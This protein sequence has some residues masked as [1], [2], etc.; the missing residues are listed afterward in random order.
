M[1]IRGELFLLPALLASSLA[2]SQIPTGTIAGSVVDSSAASLAGASVQI[3][4]S[5]T[6][7]PRE[8]ITE[9]SGTFRVAN[10]PPG[11]YE[12]TVTKDGFHPLRQTGIQVEL[13]R[14]TELKLVLEV[15]HVTENLD[16]AAGGKG[17]DDAFSLVSDLLKFDEI[18]NLVQDSRTVTDLAYLVSGVGRNA[19][20]GLGSGFV[21]GGARADNTNFILD[22]F[23]DY[24]PR[25]G[26]A[27]AMP[28]Y[29]AVQEFRVQTTGSVAEFGHMAGG[30]MNIVLR[31]GTNRLHGSAFEF[32]RNSGLTARNFFDEQKSYLL[33][34]QFGATLSGPVTAPHL[35]NGHDRTFF[36]VSWE[37]LHQSSGQNQLSEVPTMLERAGDFSQSLGATGKP[38]V[39][40]DPLTRSPFPLDRIPQSR[41]DP[42]AARL[43]GFYP[44]P[45]NVD[46]TDNFHADAINRNHFDS[47]LLKLDEHPD[48]KDVVAFRY[49]TRLNATA[50]PYS[51]SGLGLFGSNARIQP[52]LAGVNYTRIIGPSMVNELRAGFTRM[53]DHE[54][55]GYAGQD[56]NGLVGL[57]S[58]SEPHQ[59]GFPS[60]TILNLA[61]LGDSPSM[62]ID[63][64][65]NDYEIAD[66][67]S[68]AKGRHIIRAGFDVLRTQFFRN[69]DSNTRG[70]YN[71]LGRWST[72][73]FAD[74]LLG[75]PDSTTRQSSS[76][77]AYFFYTNWGAFVQ[78][79]FE[80]NSRLTLSFGIR[81]EINNPPT[82]KYGRMSSFVPQIGKVVIADGSTI[83]DL[84]QRLAA[85]GLTGLV[86]TAAQAGLP[87]SLVYANHH[88]FAPRFGF[89]LRP[90]ASSNTVVRGGYGIYYADSL[91]NPILN[92]LS[93]VYP[94][95]V[96]QTFSRNAAQPAALTLENPFPTS[97]AS[98]PGVTNVNG[99]ALHPSPQY[100][101]SYSLSVE[102]Q[103]GSSTTLELE[104][105]G[106][107][108]THLEQQY[109]LNQPFRQ[110]ALQLPNGNFPR[111]FG[112]FGT[113]NFYDFGAN[114]FYNSG[115]VTVRR[116]WRS[117][118][119]YG[120][121][122]IF[123]KSIDD[124]SQTSGNSTGD[125]P[126][127]QNSRDLA[128]ERGRSD[129]DNKHSLLLFGSYQLP[130]RG[131]HWIRGW[132]ISATGRFY[133]GQPFTPRVAN[134]NLNLGEAD[135][136]DRIAN[137]DL[138][139][140]SVADWFNLAAFPVV[141]RRAFRFGN[142]GR[143]IVDGPASETVNA[144]LL[145]NF[146][147]PEH[148][149]LQFRAEAINL[150][151]HA[152][153]GLPVNFVD[154]QNAGQILSADSPRVIQ[155]GLR[156]QF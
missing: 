93:N 153:F 69:L 97:L 113:V 130:F 114:S 43:A 137:G 35:Y 118:L 10:I 85:A 99:F 139:N 156:V 124:A 24:D 147:L 50:N 45:N 70:T 119:F 115:S 37:S 21:V 83:P 105:A 56:I 22:G 9:A 108:G 84:S 106:S 102:H 59:F 131:N 74:F 17:I 111:P 151:N 134:A 40:T 57:P 2:Y 89:T 54:A 73:P 98:L 46:P 75:L 51:G 100:L 67:V 34:N 60:I 71:F 16:V 12:V 39:I 126:G 103:I 125:Y 33:R 117:G 23:S 140:P 94:F 7:S 135:R 62:P 76:G 128:A 5:G 38:V 141:A 48:D 107:R 78:D 13:E 88:D 55:S 146:A 90:L 96:S 150:L 142:S 36:L 25:T 129:W 15:G 66:T 44:L 42:I 121:S 65:G 120:V 132:Q 148:R 155:L 136:P 41:L 19:R 112:G 8:A 101:Q 11:E 143:N 58:V 49:L 6:D 32:F 87:Q 63:F 116:S 152:N 3:R 144:A 26:G 20:G 123:A 91:A 81:Y 53:T 82:E 72:A 79:Q 92:S 4:N 64:T 1:Y 86:T 27:Q 104:Y 28:N 149:T 31:N 68:R 77:P 122:Y 110:A 145:K 133:S 18:M 138:S 80:V 52:T 61:S 47:V 30:V 95:T 14:T 154:A 109:D 29:D 127:A